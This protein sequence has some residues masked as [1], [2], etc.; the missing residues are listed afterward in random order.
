MPFASISEI[1]SAV[2]GIFQQN[3]RERKA[4]GSIVYM[5]KSPSSSWEMAS[6][7]E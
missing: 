1:A 4:T 6:L 5:I 7:D 3:N 2:S